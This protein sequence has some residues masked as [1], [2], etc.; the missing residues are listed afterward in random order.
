MGIY[1]VA[2][3]KAKL[4]IGFTAG[5]LAGIQA[6][7]QV[8]PGGMVPEMHTYG[9]EGSQGDR[10]QTEVKSGEKSGFQFK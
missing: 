2:V 1:S 9:M 4:W 3:E 8:G 6:P 7:W 10:I 5:C